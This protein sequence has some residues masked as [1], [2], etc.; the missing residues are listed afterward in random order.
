MADRVS[1]SAKPAT[2]E[3]GSAK[4]SFPAT[5]AQLYGATRPAY[6]SQ[7][8]HRHRRC[9]TFC[10]WFL[11]VIVILLLLIVVSGTVLYLL[12]RPQSPSL[13]INS[14]KLSHLNM[15]SFSAFNSKFE[16]NIN[17]TNPNKKL[18]SPSSS[19]QSQFS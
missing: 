17:A 16:L 2:A 10:I 5:K 19:I 3:Y 6:P 12:Y 1:P 15:T 18:N 11:L 7:P 9:C 13:T 14:F 4:P 8:Y